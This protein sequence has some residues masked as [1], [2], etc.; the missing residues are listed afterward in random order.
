MARTRKKKRFDVKKLG[1]LVEAACRA[2][3]LLFP[4]QKSGA[5]KREWVVKILNEK[6]NIP[7]LSEKQE[8]DI[9]GIIV[10]VVCDLIFTV[11]NA[12]RYE[13]SDLLEK[14]KNS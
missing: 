5:E 3:E 2:A 13:V 10:D 9:L 11:N 4:E 14:L 8:A 1:L 12:D 7:F 6:L